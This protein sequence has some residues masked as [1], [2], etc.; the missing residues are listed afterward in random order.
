MK[1]RVSFLAGVSLAIVVT[2]IVGCTMPGAKS[3]SRGG[4]SLSIN[5]G[6]GAKT[7]LPV[8]SAASYLI[9]F[10]G[11]AQQ[12]P[13]STTQSNPTI[14]LEA[15]TWNISVEGKDSGGNTVAVGGASGVVVTT[16]A[17]TPVS[18][19]LGAQSSGNGTIDVTVTW[20]TLT[21]VIDSCVVTVGPVGGTAVAVPPGT[22]TF[23]P[24]GTSV[25]YTE[26]KAAGNY[27]LSINLYSGAVLRAPVQEAV[28]V[29]GN[30]SSS[31]TIA[32]V[33]ADFTLP[34]AA[35]SGLAVAE[36]LG[37]LDLSWVDNSHVATSYEVDR[38][39]DNVSFAVLTA[40]LP[41]NTSSYRD[42]T[43][44]MGQTYWYRVAAANSLG[45]TYSTAAS[46]EVQAPIPGGSGALTFGAV[47]SSSIPVSWQKGTDNV[48]VQSALA[49][50]VVYSLSNNVQTV[51]DAQA[52]GTVARDWTLDVTTANVTGLSSGTLYYFNVLVKDGAGNISAYVSNS[53]ATLSPGVSLTITVTSP[54]DQTIT[55]SQV[56]DIVVAPDATLTI[57]TGGGFDSYAWVLDGTTLSGQTTAT[58][59]IDCSTLVLGAHHVTIFVQKNGMGYSNTLRF[60]IQS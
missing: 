13:V 56:N 55:F 22:V 20:P 33:A 47:S 58:A 16:G 30:L 32:L 14:E 48:S 9:S 59:V 27:Q 45:S 38:S 28:Q 36:G 1:E 5:S 43:A 6:G 21:P 53:T 26:G 41:P 24:G 2:L 40:S 44:A 8:I 51:G 46:G 60:Q 52:N 39:T 12:S 23:T 11:P 49:Y 10:S 7:V 15:G 19:V 37:E 34:P 50:K 3:S 54:Q 31:A 17:I 29:Y 4:I 25:R 57:T 35:P 18:I 42:T